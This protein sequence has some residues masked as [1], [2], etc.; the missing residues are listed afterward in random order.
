MTSGDLFIKR[1]RSALNDAGMTQKDLARVLGL[2]CSTVNGWC[3][4]RYMPNAAYLPTIC[5]TLGIS[6]DWLLGLEIE[7]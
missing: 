1:L 3:R 2:D 6:A 4:G 7:Q 5:T